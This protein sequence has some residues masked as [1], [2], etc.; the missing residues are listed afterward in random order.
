MGLLLLRVQ[1]SLSLEQF[2]IAMAVFFHCLTHP[3]LPPYWV[4]MMLAPLCVYLQ[5]V[6]GASCCCSV[7]KLYRTLCDPMDCSMPGFSVFH[8]LP[9]FALIPV[10]QVG[11]AINHL[12]FCHALLLPQPFPASGS[13]SVSQL[14]TAGGRSIGFSASTSVLPMSIQDWFSLGMTG[15]I[16]FQ[17]RGL[18]KVF[19]STTIQKHQFFST[20]PSL[21]SNL[22]VC[23]WLL[24]QP[25]L[26]L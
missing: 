13:F 16:S 24:E 9:E 11:D 12:I 23:T 10:H 19:F 4:G 6:W 25:Q 26:W 15:L 7:T 17:P 22:Y 8:Y 3:L 2:R 18:S 1:K 20:Q 5:K 14:F 21:W